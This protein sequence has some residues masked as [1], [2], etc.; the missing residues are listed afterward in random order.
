MASTLTDIEIGDATGAMPDREVVVVAP[1]ALHLATPQVL[2][3]CRTLVETG[4]SQIRLNP[5]T[6][7]S[8]P[9]STFH[10]VVV[11][12]PKT[13]GLACLRVVGS[14][15]AAHGDVKLDFADQELVDP[16]P[17]QGGLNTTSAQAMSLSQELSDAKLALAG[18]ESINA[19]QAMLLEALKAKA[20]DL[21]P[22]K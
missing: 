21:M 18:L 14:W 6:S 20:L 11:G 9:G 12:T 15:L 19:K 10:Q 22:W 5:P 4:A 7:T 2:L 13:A 1:A 8:T 3:G 16:N 17:S